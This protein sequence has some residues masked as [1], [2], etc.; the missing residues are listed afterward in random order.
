MADSQPL[1]AQSSCEFESE[2]LQMPNITTFNNPGTRGGSGFR[3][4]TLAEKAGEKN[5]K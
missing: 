2:S 1:L 3:D 4:Q 5:K